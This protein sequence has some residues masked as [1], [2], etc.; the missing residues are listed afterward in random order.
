MECERE[1]RLQL[2]RLRR[3]WLAGKR[4]KKKLAIMRVHKTISL[5]SLR[6]RCLDLSSYP[7]TVGACGFLG[8]CLYGLDKH[9]LWRLLGISVCL[10]GRG[11]GGG[12]VGVVLG[13]PLNVRQRDG[14]DDGALRARPGSGALAQ[15]RGAIGGCHDWKRCVVELKTWNRS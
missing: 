9:A 14:G 5:I 13:A 12:A 11:L 6:G 1:G 4:R 15:V 8:L 3:W 10:R 2:E 7:C